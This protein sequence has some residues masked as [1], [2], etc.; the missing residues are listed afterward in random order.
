MVPVPSIAWKYPS[1]NVSGTN[2]ST[3]NNPE[4]G[5]MNAPYGGRK[6]S[7]HGSE[8]VREG[9]HA[10]LQLKHLRIRYGK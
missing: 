4:A 5:I 7:G 9:L 3:S 2:V 8:H 6:V 10:Y 1:P